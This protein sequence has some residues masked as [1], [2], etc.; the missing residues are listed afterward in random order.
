MDTIHREN[1]D[2]LTAAAKR[3]KRLVFQCLEDAY[4]DIGK[5]YRD[6]HSDQTVAEATQAAIE[7]VRQVL[8][9]DFDP[10]S[11]PPEI[12]AFERRLIAAYELHIKIADDLAAYKARKGWA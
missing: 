11:A 1:L 5:R 6:G 2:K 10:L 8:E 12:L 4:D 7:F 3:V 9:E